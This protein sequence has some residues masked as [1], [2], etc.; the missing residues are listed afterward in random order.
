MTP[1]QARKAAEVLQAFADGKSIQISAINGSPIWLDCFPEHWDNMNLTK[2]EFR[3]K[4]QPK[5][6]WV[7]EHTDQTIAYPTKSA[8]PLGLPIIKVREVLD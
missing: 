8:N 3:I 7:V 1:D 6:W 5:E 4:P 2:S